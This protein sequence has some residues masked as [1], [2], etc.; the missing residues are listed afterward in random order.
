MAKKSF[1]MISLLFKGMNKSSITQDFHKGHKALDITPPKKINFGY[2]TP[3]CAPENCLVLGINGDGFTAFS[4]KNFVYGYG[5]K[6]KGLETGHEYLFWHCLP[7]FPVWGGDMVKRGQIVAYMGNSGKVFQG[8]KEVELKDRDQLPF[9]PKNPEEDGL[10]LHFE[11]YKNGKQIDPTPHFNW[12]WQPQYGAL[13][14]IR[15]SL[16]VI[17]KIRKNIK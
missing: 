6:L 17:N 8:N 12:S 16:V 15:A 4:Y 9:N 1:A 13:D 3:L 2:G 11:M 7:M 5:I 14:Q 10:H